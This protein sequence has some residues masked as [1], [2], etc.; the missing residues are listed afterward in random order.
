MP[1]FMIVI[2]EN[3]SEQARLSP[4]ETRTLVEAHT[5][6]VEKLKTAGAYCDGERLRPSVEG[7]R[8]RARNG[9][10]QVEP[11]PFAGE[12]RALAGYYVVRAADL[13]AAVSLAES[14]PIAPGDTLDVRPVM[15][16][17]VRANKTHARGK[18]FA[19][20]ILGNE[21]NERGWVEV[22]DR[23]DAET[24]SLFP[25]DRFLGGVRLEAPGRGRQIVSRGGRR[26]M[27][28]G[29]FLESKEVIGGVFFLRV[30]SLDDAVQWVAKT[31]FVQHGALEVRELW[32]S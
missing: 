29:P 3:E 22:M 30:E 7:R 8:V 20:V 1:E 16:G 15:K 6:Y 21:A 19:F 31:P 24:R 18:T 27:M 9:R 4:S 14:C 12:D 23:I 10:V 13:G 26:A 32:R 2:H 28:D 5:S 11:G 17:D 25:A